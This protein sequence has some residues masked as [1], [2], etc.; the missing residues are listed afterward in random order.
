MDNLMLNKEP[1]V[2]RKDKAQES[3][4]KDSAQSGS[5]WLETL[6]TI[7]VA[8]LIAV[9]VRTFAY[10]PFNIPSS[11][12]EPTLLIGDYLF[13]SKLSYGY[14]RHS[15]PFGLPLFSGRIL[16][17]EPEV[18]DVA[19]FAYPRDNKTDYIKRIV[20]LPGDKIAVREGVLHINDAPVRRELLSASEEAELGYGQ[21]GFLYYETLPNGRRHLIRE[22]NDE[23]R[24]DNFPPVVV[25][26]GHYFAMGDNR[27]NSLDSRA[28]VGFVP[29]E[30]LVGRAD[31]LFFSHDG[32][33]SW[34]EF[35]TW[36]STIRFGRIGDAIE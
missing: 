9:G 20:G 19:V 25:P 23:Q 5:A 6:R 8:V 36:P 29:F 10:E 14:S 16:F 33:S 26:E 3:G 18:G 21:G 34:W 32:S 28:D 11:S 35:W 24:Y 13:V 1:D 7:V 2:D 12:M 30:N 4:A 27:D 31:I 15:L 17:S 22:I